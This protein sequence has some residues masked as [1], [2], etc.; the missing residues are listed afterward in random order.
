MSFVKPITDPSLTKWA[1]GTIAGVL[2]AGVFAF[3]VMGSI[4]FSKIEKGAG[5]LGGGE[6]TRTTDLRIMRTEQG[7]ALL[8]K[9]STLLLFST[10]YKSVDLIRSA[11]KRSVL[12][13]QPLR[14]H[15]SGGTTG[16]AFVCGEKDL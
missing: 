13:V 4:A 14:F 2:L 8:E 6:W 15:D 11:L 16:C 9:F 3:A 12:I 1:L 10:G 7:S 5:K